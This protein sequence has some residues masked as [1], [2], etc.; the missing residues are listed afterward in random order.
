MRIVR[1]N[2]A[3]KNEMQSG[4]FRELLAYTPSY[5]LTKLSALKGTVSKPHS[6]MHEQVV[7]IL[8]GEGNFLIGEEII[9]MKAGDCI[10]ID[11]DVPH[12][13]DSVCE[14][15]VWFE[16]FTPERKDITQA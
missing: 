4:V 15:M 1:N 2:E 16:F 3:P 10:Q 14:D 5:T 8:S 6:H 12:T 9:N 11:A 7:Y 13:F